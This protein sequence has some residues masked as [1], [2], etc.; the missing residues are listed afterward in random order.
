MTMLGYLPAAPSMTYSDAPADSSPVAV[1]LDD[2]I[3]LDGAWA[4]DAG[5]AATVPGVMAG[6]T[7]A[8]SGMS[9]AAAV[10]GSGMAGLSVAGS[11]MVGV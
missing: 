11:T 7:P 9:V 6:V 2:V 1:H 3:A 8:G 10:T 4:L 5:F